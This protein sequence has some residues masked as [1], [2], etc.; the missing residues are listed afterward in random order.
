MGRIQCGCNEVSKR[1]NKTKKRY[2]P[3]KLHQGHTWLLERG[4]WGPHTA[5]YICA[6]CAGA[7]I[8]WVTTKQ[9]IKN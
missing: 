2:E 1:M 4:K 5:R 3:V 8:K 6:N 9:H 7:H